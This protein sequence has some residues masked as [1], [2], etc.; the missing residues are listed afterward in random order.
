M[1]NDFEICQLLKNQYDGNLVADY[2]GN[3]QDVV[4]AVKTIGDVVYVLHEGTHDIPDVLHDFEANIA[5]PFILNGGGVHAGFWE[6]M[7][8]AY[9]KIVSFLPKDKQI[10][11]TGHSLGAG[12]VNVAAAILIC[13]YGYNPANI[14]RVKFASPRSNDLA[15]EN[16]IS[17]SP[18]RSYWNYGSPLSNDIVCT[19]PK[20]FLGFQY[21]TE[22]Q[23][24][25]IWSPP[26]F[27]DP[28]GIVAW[29]HIELYLKALGSISSSS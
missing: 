10:V 7:V 17:K 8:A 15:L 22:E 18:L 2:F 21:Y 16:Q 12:R 29:H 20:E 5:R 14:H 4:F 1:L 26:Y 25:K 13:A 9:D 24:I 27:P 11:L 19:V 6:G 23:K 3:I 28:W